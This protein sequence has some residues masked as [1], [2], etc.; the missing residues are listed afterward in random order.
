MYFMFFSWSVRGMGYQGN[1]PPSEDR[2]VTVAGCK[3]TIIAEPWSL[4]LGHWAWCGPCLSKERRGLSHLASSVTMTWIVSEGGLCKRILMILE[5]ELPRRVRSRVGALCR[6]VVNCAPNLRKLA[7]ISFRAS[8]EGC[9]E[10]WQI[11][12]EIESKFRTIL[13]KY[14]QT[15]DLKTFQMKLCL[16]KPYKECEFT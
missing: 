4:F 1:C 14:S 16:L 6:F 13:C 11:C 5:S 3:A 12:R 9:A 7:G 8:E 2:V 15:S 10:L